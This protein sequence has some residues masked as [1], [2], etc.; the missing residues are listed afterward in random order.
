[1]VMNGVLL[2]LPFFVV[3]F[4]LLLVLNPGALAR[5]AYFA[6]MQGREKAAYYIYQ[7][8]NIAMFIYLFFLI[9]RPGDSWQFYYRIDLLYSGA[10]L[11]YGGNGGFLFS[12]RDG[13]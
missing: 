9:I 6:P 11:M 13:I 12:G 1:M 8:C 3:R 5:A 2:F 7:I 4:L 10:L